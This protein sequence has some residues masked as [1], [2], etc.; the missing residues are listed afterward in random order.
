MRADK[1]LFADLRVIENRYPHSD[2]APKEGAKRAVTCLSLNPH[3]LCPGHAPQ[4]AFCGEKNL[5][6]LHRVV[7]S[8]NQVLL[9][10]FGPGLLSSS[11]WSGVTFSL[12][13]L[14]GPGYFS[15]VR[16]YFC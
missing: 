3:N 16:G 1:A 15:L 5:P 11:L 10:L 8:W 4:G 2:Q 13:V 6:F 14:F 9:V 7:A 12:R